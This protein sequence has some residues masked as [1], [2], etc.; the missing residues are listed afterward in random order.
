MMT[1]DELELYIVQARIFREFRR[2][3][4]QQQLTNEDRPVRSATT[5]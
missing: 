3:R 5:L 1:L 4:T 2:F